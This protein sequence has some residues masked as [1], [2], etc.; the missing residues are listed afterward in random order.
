MDNKKKVMIVDDEQDFLFITKMNLEETGKYEVLT[1]SN[2]KNIISEIHK[3]KPD[4]LLLDMLM[5]SIGGPEV[6]ELLNQDPIGK[7]VPII[8]LSALDKDKDKLKAFKQ[9][10]VDYATKPIDKDDMINKI[11]KALRYK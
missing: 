1:L 10:V 5:P 7:N 6:C 8:I 9:G 3:F 4:I 2:A 11:E